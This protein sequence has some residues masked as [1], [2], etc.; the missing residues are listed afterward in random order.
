MG[1]GLIQ[2]SAYGRENS[3]LNDNPKITFFKSVYKTGKCWRIFWF[4]LFK[5]VG[6]LK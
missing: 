5:K 2:I 6:P 1:G 3:Y 4:F